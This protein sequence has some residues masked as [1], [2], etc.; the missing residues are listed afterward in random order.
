MDGAVGERSGE[1]VVHATVLIDE[2][3][4]VEVG[5]HDGDLEVVPAAGSILDVDRRSAG[6]G[7]LEQLTYRRGLHGI[8]LVAS[9][10]APGMRLFR[11]LLL[12]KLGFWA[13]MFASAALL[14][15]AHED[16]PTLRIDGFTAFGGFAV[17]AKAAES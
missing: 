15:R 9:G 11:A 12:F 10:Y 8:M 7:V 16:A 13:G 4:A 6:K 14:K 2:R 5:A 3:K 17:G 1:S